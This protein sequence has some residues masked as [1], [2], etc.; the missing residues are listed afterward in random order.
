[1][2]FLPPPGPVAQWVGAGVRHVGK[3]SWIPSPPPYRET[4]HLEWIIPPDGTG[5][6]HVPEVLEWSLRSAARA[7]SASKPSTRTPPG[8]SPNPPAAIT[9]ELRLGGRAGSGA[10]SVPRCRKQL[11]RGAVVLWTCAD[12][13]QEAIRLGA[14]VDNS[15][16]WA[17]RLSVDQ[18][19]DLDALGMRW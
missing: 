14:F 17:A 9:H 2:G 15:R 4:G 19:A 1:M 5:A 11:P 10:G 8:L 12:R 13:Q 3:G 16:R 18:R 7:L 6:L